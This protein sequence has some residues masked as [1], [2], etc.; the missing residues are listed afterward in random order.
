MPDQDQ[1]IDLVTLQ[2]VERLLNETELGRPMEVEAILA[3]P[4]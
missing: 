4:V 3:A 2:E 1:H